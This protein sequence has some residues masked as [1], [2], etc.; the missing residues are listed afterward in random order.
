MKKK[1]VIVLFLF[2]LVALLS[3]P[4]Y[5][6]T[7]KALK[8]GK[9]YKSLDFNGD[10]KK[11]SFKYKYDGK[12]GVNGGKATFTFNGHSQKIFVARGLTVNY[13]KYSKK[14]IYLFIYMHQYGGGTMMVYRYKGNKLV[15]VNGSIAQMASPSFHH[16]S[17]KYVYI[18][19]SPYHQDH[20]ASLK[21]AEIGSEYGYI[22]SF[23]VKYQL[24][25]KKRNFSLASRYADTLKPYPLKY[26]GD[27]YATS[28]N[29]ISIDS[30][31]LVLHYGDNVELVQAYFK[32]I[33][34]TYPYYKLYL[35]V[36]SNNQSGWFESSTNV[37]FV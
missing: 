5:S 26:V 29:P 30:N 16:T 7:T 23:L 17:G 1:L 37:P 19:E 24:N 15:K 22:T 2:I 27:I 36:R 12:Y 32:K 34:G 25:T 33:V 20:I 35:K 6:S 11:D 3:V 13:M 18:K 9:T 21:E 14:Q 8:Q 4:V 10:G 31:G 28:S